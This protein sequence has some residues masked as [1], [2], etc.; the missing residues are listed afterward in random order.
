MQ[1]NSGF[2]SHSDLLNKLLQDK[3]EAAGYLSAALEE[4]NDELFF[5]AL[6]NIANAWGLKRLSKET[7]ET[8]Y[9]Q[10]GR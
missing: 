6:K 4:G 9:A 2:K 8:V 7:G 1:Q 5:L 3:K 10:E